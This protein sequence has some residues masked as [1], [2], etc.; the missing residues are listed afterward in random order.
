[1]YSGIYESREQAEAHRQELTALGI[2][3]SFWKHVTRKD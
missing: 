1:V 2:T 3:P